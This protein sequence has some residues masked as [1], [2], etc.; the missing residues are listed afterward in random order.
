MLML[1]TLRDI[2]PSVISNFGSLCIERAESEPLKWL[3]SCTSPACLHTYAFHKWG[4]ILSE[5]VFWPPA[6]PSLV[7]WPFNLH[8]DFW[9][10]RSWEIKVYF[11]PLK[12]FRSC[13]PGFFFGFWCKSNF[14]FRWRPWKK[15]RF[16]GPEVYL[17]FEADL[18][19]SR[20]WFSEIKVQI[21]RP[22]HLT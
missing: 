16:A 11:K 9:K 22:I 3:L 21:K 12:N 15:S 17:R 4:Q 6:Q 1:A 8:L 7:S 5:F 2:F 14:F 19:F 20:P 18:D 10:W 13:K